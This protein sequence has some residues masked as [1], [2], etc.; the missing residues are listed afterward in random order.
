MGHDG[1]MS[2]TSDTPQ[3]PGDW[4]GVDEQ[5][6]QRARERALDRFRNQRDELVNAFDLWLRD[7]RAQDPD[8]VAASVRMIRDILR[9]KADVHGR[10]DPLDWDAETM[11]ELITRTVPQELPEGI[12]L[13]DAAASDMYFFVSFLGAARH[14]RKKPLP[15]PTAHAILTP[16]AWG[17]PE[18]NPENWIEIDLGEQR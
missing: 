12:G 18:E 6:D 11:Q 1:P 7:E 13:P 2:R 5:A 10:P 16:I 9:L 8:E 3:L 14:W 17:T 15:A 4:E